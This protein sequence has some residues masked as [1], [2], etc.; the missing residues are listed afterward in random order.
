MSRVKIFSASKIAQIDY[1]DR[2]IEIADD[3][4]FV[5]DGSKS[6]CGF[7]LDIFGER[8]RIAITDPVYPVYVDTNVMAGHTGLAERIGTL[9]RDLYLPCRAENGFVPEPPNEHADV[10]YLC[11]PNNPDGR[12]RDPGSSWSAGSPT[13]ESTRRCCSTTRPTKV[14]S[15]I[16]RSRARSLKFPAARSA[17]WNFAAFRRRADSPECGAVLR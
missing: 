12:G 14:T 11:F 9:R 6:D 15:A 10:V 3:E 7:I 5:S 16:R 4:I 1:R 17:R 2:G 8:N 13:R